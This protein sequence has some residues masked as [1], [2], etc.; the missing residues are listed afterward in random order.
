M[1]IAR[2]PNIVRDSLALV[3]DPASERCY[4]GSGSTVFDLSGNNRNGTLGNG[5]SVSS[6]ILNFTDS[7]DNVGYGTSFIIGD[8][9]TLSFWIKSDRPLSTTDNWEIGFLNQGSTQ[10]TMFGMMYG[11]GNCQDLGFWGYGSPYDMSVEAVNNK[12]SS[13]GNWHNVVVTEDS[14]RN[15]KIWV[16]NIQKQWLKHSD[17]ST[18]V[19]S[20][21]LPVATTNYF[22][23]NSRGGWTSGTTY[24]NLADVMVYNKALSGDEISQ[25]Y[26]A[27]KSRF[28]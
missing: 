13:D 19:Y 14:S 28:G 10:G 5:L 9:K 24:I 17:Y 15:V 1:G 26:N 20:V 12:W 6:G 8:A 27:L 22:L 3:T 23:I 18:L 25:N 11:V 16:D 2:G 21:Q 4:P 7:G